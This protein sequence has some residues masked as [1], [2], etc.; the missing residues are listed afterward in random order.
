MAARQLEAASIAA[1]EELWLPS[2]TTLPDRTHCVNDVPRFQSVAT[3]DTG[4]ARRT[5]SQRPAFRQKLWAS[6]A[7][8]RAVHSSSAGESGVGGVHDRV[9]VEGGDV[10]EPDFDALAHGSI[11]RQEQATIR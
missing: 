7:V 10:A 4:F 3:R 1:G 9:H 2:V 11:M 5:T 8:D 6:R